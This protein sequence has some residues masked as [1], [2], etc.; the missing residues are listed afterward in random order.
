MTAR[1]TNDMYK[2]KPTYWEYGYQP[3]PRFK[4]STATLDA[5]LKHAVEELNANDTYKAVIIE[6]KTFHGYVVKRNAKGEYVRESPS[7]TV[8][9]WDEIGAVVS[10]DCAWPDQR[11]R[12]RYIWIP[13]KGIPKDLTPKNRLPQVR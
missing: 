13:N 4:G 10:V 3:T 12:R 1:N 8:Y 9:G 11:Y 7:A 6:R 5:I 2:L